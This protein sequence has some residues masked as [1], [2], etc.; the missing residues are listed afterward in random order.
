MLEVVVYLVAR[1]RFD[2]FTFF[3]FNDMSRAVGHTG[4]F[5]IRI[6][7]EKSAGFAV[8]ISH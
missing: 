2:M 3:A 5:K 4:M 7:G 8:H 6:R 1:W